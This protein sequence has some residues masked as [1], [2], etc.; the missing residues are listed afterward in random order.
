MQRYRGR[1]AAAVAL[2]T[3]VQV[4]CV[5]GQV[6]GYENLYDPFQV[7]NLNFEMDPGDW[8]T[9]RN[10][11]DYT[12]VRPAYFWADDEN[13]IIVSI[14]R[15]PNL[16]NGDKI[17]LK[18]DIN[19]YFDG[20][21]WHGVKKLSLENGYDADAVTEGLAWWLHRQ[22]SGT[23]V[24]DYKPPLA[25]WVNV[26]VNGQLLGMYANVEQVDKTFLRNRDQWVSGE[27]WLYKQGEVGPSELK[28]GEGDSPIIETLNYS[29]FI[30]GGDAPPPDY[31]AE[32][33]SLIDMEQMLTVGAIEAFI[34]N[35]D[36]L[37]TKGKNFF[38]ADYAPGA[39]PEPGKRLYQPWDL[40]AV[41]GGQGTSSI[42]DSKGQKFDA[43]R[44]YI[45]DVPHFRD[46]YNQIM[47]DLLNSPMSVEA[48][49]DFLEQLEP[50]LRDSIMADPD[51]KIGSTPEAVASHF[52]SLTDW[53]TSRHA[54]VLQQ[55]LD[56]MAAS[57][58]LAQAAQTPEP[59]T[60]ALLAAVM[61]AGLRRRCRSTVA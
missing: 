22:A 28:A 25:S 57:A 46:Q 9:V 26:T 45:T 12:E 13:K 15:K 35:Y 43:Y 50:V 52:D 61:I 24:T 19:E 7:L 31:I 34:G 42:Y 16:A 44:Q 41:L 4:A 23:G 48:Y 17:A 30:S 21:R 39:G 55:V 2:V 32:M 33:E 6:P 5:H 8:S 59:S 1:I 49:T 14:K 18:I 54:N 27:T 29:P 47:L 51:S 60:M 3:I 10:D 38:F 11:G 36:G 56:D 37:L 20:L 58:P 40:D 53:Y